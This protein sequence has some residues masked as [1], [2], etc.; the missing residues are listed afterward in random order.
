MPAATVPAIRFRR[1]LLTG[2]AGGLGREMRGRLR[3]HCETLRVS[4]CAPLDAASDGEE[5][6]VVG[7]EDAA[8][9]AEL[10]KDVDAV[11]HLGAVS[12]EQPW[13]AILPANIIGAYNLYEAARRNGVKRILFASS[14][15]VTGFYRQDQVI[16]SRDPVR[17]DGLYGLSK[18]FGENL[19]QLYWDRHG[20]ETVS[21]RIGS[22]FT[23]PKDRRML[24]TWMSY[25]DTERLFVA[26]LTAPV[27]GHTVIYGMSDN[28]TTW[29]DN[30]HARHVGYRPQ[31]SS[32]QFRAAVE[33]RQPVL[34]PSDPA[35]VFQGGVFVR[36]GPFE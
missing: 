31:D 23:E 13:E 15:H 32:E 22:A 9:V 28:A 33:A 29:W 18:A 3:A 12:V 7:L 25:D 27:V 11:I 10:L 24:A 8:A 36:T 34:D 17:P 4:D 21:V 16:D 2:A 19:A 30:R 20:I 1:L 14:N 35:V 26:A 5:T 6:A